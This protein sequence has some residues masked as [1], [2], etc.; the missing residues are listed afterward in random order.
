MSIEEM[1]YRAGNQFKLW[2]QSRNWKSDPG[3]SPPAPTIGPTGSWIASPTAIPNKQA[4]LAAADDILEGHMAVFSLNADAYGIVNAWNRDPKTKIRTP[5]TFGKSLN[6]HNQALVGDIKY[7]WEPNRHL[8]LVTLAQ[9]YFLSRREVYLKGI[10]LHI[11][12]WMDQCPYLLGPNWCSSL[13][14][15]IRLINWSIVWQ[16][17]GGS[18]SEV[19]TQPHG[20]IF[21]AKWLGSIFQH[22]EFIFRNFS[23]HSS[24]NNHLIGEAAGL[25][26]ACNTWP[27]WDGVTNN[28][29]SKSRD[30]LMAEVLKQ[31][32]P[33]GVTREQAVSYQQFVLDFLIMSLVSAKDNGGFFPSACLTRIEKMLE[34]IAALMDPAGNLP[35]IGDSD[36]GYAVR[37]SQEP[38]FCPYRSLLATGAII[39]NRPDLLQCAGRVDDKTRWLL[40]EAAESVSPTSKQTFPIQRS[41]P[42]GGYYILGDDLRGPEEIRCLIDCGPLGYLSI[43]AHGHADALSLYLA[44]GGKEFL[45]DPGTYSYGGKENWRKYFRGTSAHNTARI[46]R[47]DQSVSGGNF[48]WIDKACTQV[49]RFETTQDLD[50]FE[51]LHDG[52]KR[53]SDPLTHTRKVVLNKRRRTVSV[54][55]S[56]HCHKQH[57]VERFWHFSEECKVQVSEGSILAENKGVKI[58]ITTGENTRLD[59]HFGNEASPMG[60]ISRHY[61]LKVPCY[62]AVMTDAITGTTALQTEIKIIM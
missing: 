8:H 24:A 52:Y 57:N 54:T 25:F 27:Y 35:M 22:M 40:G 60:W 6:Y 18:Q 14:I 44:V 61:E 50:L 30:L 51:G 47:G 23:R 42:N 29:K 58:L 10:R 17:I 12:S 32:H 59:L 19:F 56:F 21:L 33:D 4:Y 2:Y 1:V 31:T 34:F 15:A 62:T 45:I 20:K 36:D 7:L 38:G 11:H 48:M 37:L 9:A 46:D 55:D 53:L 13:E 28:W 39:F 41:F 3:L 43:A 26:I 49:I 5:L 16:L